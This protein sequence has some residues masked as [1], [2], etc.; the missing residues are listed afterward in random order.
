M[1]QKLFLK[2]YDANHKIF[3][4][5][6][7]RNSVNYY[8]QKS[9][10]NKRGIEWEFTLYSWIEWW[11]NT[12]HFHERG[13]NNHQY[14]MCRKNDTGAYSVEN[15]YCDTG[16]NNKQGLRYSR[17]NNKEITINGITY[18]SISEAARE[19]RCHRST[20]YNRWIK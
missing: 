12:G 5:Y 1:K 18:K 6:T 17:T 14:Q 20:I 10:A 16:L 19:L 3:Q 9:M 8:G 13:V 15:V 4:H 11:V 7:R 2:E